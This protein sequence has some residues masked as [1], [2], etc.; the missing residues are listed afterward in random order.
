[1]TLL[2]KQ[3]QSSDFIFHLHFHTL[4]T[5]EC[6]PQ[7]TCTN[8]RIAA[9]LSSI[10]QNSFASASIE[11]NTVRLKGNSPILAISCKNTAKHDNYYFGISKNSMLVVTLFYLIVDDK[12][13]LYHDRKNDE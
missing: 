2:Q 10:F 12:N 13:G 11:N 6:I 5:P 9:N 4:A 8:H 7:I 1:M 3:I